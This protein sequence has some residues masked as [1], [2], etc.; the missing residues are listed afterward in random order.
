[1]RRAG[2]S[3]EGTVSPA[4]IGL[5]G[6]TV[7]RL[8]VW[9]H[10]RTTWNAAGRFQGQADPP[11]DLVGQEQARLA[12]A[13][14]AIDPPELIL[15]SDLVRAAST[16]AV[17]SNVTEVPLR[18]D[19]R[20]R[21][22]DLGSWQGLTRSEVAQIHPEQYAQWLA[23]RPPTGRGGESRADLD[24]RVLSALREIDVEHALIVTHGGTSRSIIETVLDLP[25]QTGRWLAVLGNC[26]WSQLRHLR[27]GWQLS[28]HNL[29]PASEA[30]Q[31]AVDSAAGEV[32]DADAVDDTAE[33]DPRAHPEA[34]PEAEPEAD[35]E[36][37]Q[38]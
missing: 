34:H 28:A 1:M 5:E 16:A 26:H 23:G 20:L 13:Y 14:L 2:G 21:E 38:H 10:G 22:V 8:T 35:A 15:T 19:R 37:G 9:R 7:T 17:L 32:G 29:A 12:A 3:T 24:R 4:R 33:A 6:L 25:R 11:L 27:G 18:V 36:V 30:M 31:P